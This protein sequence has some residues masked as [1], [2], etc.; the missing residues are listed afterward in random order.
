MHN[1]LRS[2][3]PLLLVLV[4]NGYARAQALTW[5]QVRD[6]FEATNPT[7]LADK[8][9]IDESK[10]QEITANLRP[11]PQFSL[12]VD[13]TQIAPQDGVWKPFAGTFE[14]PGIS[15]LQE[16]RHKRGLRLESAKKATQIA[17]YSH[18]DLERTLLFDLRGAF[19]SALQAKAVLHGARRS[20]PSDCPTR[21]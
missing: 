11:N 4:A 18:S 9:T 6:R 14:S 1:R 16:R 2:C 3:F 8:L 10:A 12:T 7:L 5:E 20:L 21:R 13:G 19:I 15:Q 17:E